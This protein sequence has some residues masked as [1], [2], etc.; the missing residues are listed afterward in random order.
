[1]KETV[2]LYPM[3]SMGHV[4]PMVEL[5]RLFTGHGFSVTVVL[6]D[7]P[8]MH[9]F[10][11]ALIARISFAHHCISFHRLPPIA[12]VPDPAASPIVRFLDVVRLNNPQLL[13]FLATHSLT[14]DVRAVVLDFFCIDAF[15]VTTELCLPSYFFF[16]PGASVLASFLYLPNLLSAVDLSIKDLADAPLLFPGLPPIPASHMPPI[17]M[18]RNSDSY[19][20]LLSIFQRLPDADGLLVNTFESLEAPAIR[21]LKDGACVAGRWMPPVYCIGPLVA[22]ECNIVRRG[23]EEKAE[24]MAWLEAQ[25]PRSVAF[26]CFGSSGS[27][28]FEQQKEIAAGLE[29][30]RQRFLWVVRAQLDTE[31]E[32]LLPEGF[33]ERT[34]Q[35]GFVVKSWAPQ[36][37][38][39]NHEAVGGFVTHCG[40]NSVLEAIAAGVA[41]VAWPLRSEQRMNKVLL[42][43]QMGLAVA[44]EGY[45]KELVAAEEV[46]AKVRWLIESDGGRELR[47]RA[48][49]MKQR[50]ETARKEGG[51]S[52]R[53]WLEMVE[54]LKE[55]SQK[56]TRRHPN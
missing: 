43:E 35:K 53:A 41:M 11:D 47:E 56:T 29:K 17:I 30:S 1:M 52:H 39:L 13:C 55:A 18:D 6:M 49:G 7:S 32:S 9:P 21:A 24:C 5:A 28:P 33:M 14:S 46:E 50:A 31:L 23:K 25:P 15:G 48:L 26:L 3:P 44:V 22:D 40:W 27:F 38:V 16:P 42:V 36:V 12:S 45:D 8:T 10:L 54:A 34:K 2:V 20:R 37:E 4:S 19:E 51:S